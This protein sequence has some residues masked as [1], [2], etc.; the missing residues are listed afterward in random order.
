MIAAWAAAPVMLMPLMS[1]PCT[2][3]FWLLMLPTVHVGSRRE[4]HH[5]QFQLLKGIG[6]CLFT[7]HRHRHDVSAGSQ[8]R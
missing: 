3:L 8:V 6:H 5:L 4:L 7:L 1:S 2:K